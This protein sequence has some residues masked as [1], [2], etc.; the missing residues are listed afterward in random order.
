MYKESL[1]G[2]YE[3]FYSF[4]KLLKSIYLLVHTK[5]QKC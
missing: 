4:I 3:K 2:H 1:K 5:N